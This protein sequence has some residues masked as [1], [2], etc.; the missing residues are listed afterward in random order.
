MGRS[1]ATWR[2]SHHVPVSCRLSAT[3][4]RFLGI[5]FRARD[6]V[7][8]VHVSTAGQALID[9]PLYVPRSWVDDAGRCAAAGVPDTVEF[10]TK[11]RLAQLMKPECRCR[12]KDSKPGLAEATCDSASP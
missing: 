11:P 4:V 1:T 2:S 6:G 7:F 9:R 12:T 8:L 3:G 10:A 5:L